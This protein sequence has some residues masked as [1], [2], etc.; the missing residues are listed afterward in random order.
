[1]DGGAQYNPR[2]VDEVFRDFKGRRAAMIRALTD[3]VEEFYQQ[4]DPEKENLCLYGFPNEQWEVNLPAEEVPPELPE[5]AL[6]INFARDGMQAKDWL[7]LVAVHSDAWL[8]AVAYYFGARFFFDKADRKRLFNMINDLPTIFE[9]VTGTAKKQSKEKSSVSNNSSSK[10]KSN[11]KGVKHSRAAQVKVE[12]EGFDEEEDEEH[13][14]AFC[15]ACG[16]NYAAD[17]FWIC[18][19]ICERWFHGK[20]VKI[21]PARAEHIKQYKC[22]SCGN[23]RARA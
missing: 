11:S 23:K 6:G 17:E 21:T 18:C 9:V 4:C 19:D 20:C 12:D 3:D 1:M 15:G 2:T 14:D 5:P 10:S 16:E 8:L 13:G 22:P 7:S